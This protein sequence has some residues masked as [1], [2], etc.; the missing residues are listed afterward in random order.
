MACWSTWCRT[1][2]SPVCPTR[3]AGWPASPMTRT[4]RHC[5][6]A[7]S[8][9]AISTSPTTAADA[10]RRGLASQAHPDI[11]LA[12]MQI[13]HVALDLVIE[14][15]I[16]IGEVDLPLVGFIALFLARIVTAFGVPGQQVVLGRE[17]ERVTALEV[18]AARG[19]GDGP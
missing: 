1:G 6:R 2:R 19:P 7:S 15:Q 11:G 3:N 4:Q 17:L 9:S 16:R 10:S 18:H 13:H 5:A 12:V 8:G 14:H